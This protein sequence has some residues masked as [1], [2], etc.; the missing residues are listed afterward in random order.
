M[1]M[2]YAL[3]VLLVVA[4]LLGELAVRL[5]QPALVGELMAGITLGVLLHHYAAAFPVLEA[6]TENETFGFL[7][8]LAIFFLM[9]L[10]GVEM[11][12]R[13]IASSSAKAFVVAIGG[14]LLPL[15]LGCGLGL[16]VLPDSSLRTAQVLFLGTALAISAV[17]VTV[18]VLME[19]GKLQSPLGQTIVSAAVF[20]DVLS[21][22]LL[23]LLTAVIRTGEFPDVA[24][25]AL[26]AGKVALFFVVTTLIGTYLFPR[27]GKLVRAARL[28]EFQFSALLIAGLAFALLAEALGMHFILGAFTAG[29]FFLRQTINEKVFEALKARLSGLTSGFLAPLFFVSIGMHLEPSAITAVPGFLVLLIVIGFLGKLLGSGLPA[30][31]AGFTARDASAVGTG[32]SAR[33]AIELVVADIALRAG[34]FLQPVPVPPIVEYMF[35][36]VV[37]MA[38][39]TT[40]LAPP[41]LKLL[42][43][44]AP[45]RPRP[46]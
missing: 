8:D 5:G 1:E 22:L 31:W 44:G 19:V 37:V 6:L 3:L 17:P 38:L 11:G 13:E 21:L 16:L 46:P 26:L 42:V 33:G 30:Y 32:M 4:R 18:K 10:A 29:L 2:F 24:T 41:I 20:D 14:M 12:P 45:W 43:V 23:A 35:S 25:F 40:L 7:T 36:A 34:L 28:E 15:A 27:L 39:V 9:L